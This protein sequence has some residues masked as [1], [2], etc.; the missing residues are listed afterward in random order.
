[1]A[2]DQSPIETSVELDAFT[3]PTV[4]NVQIVG[5]I[6]GTKAGAKYG[7][8]Y[9]TRQQVLDSGDRVA[10]FVYAD[11]GTKDQR[12]TEINYVSATFPGITIKREFTYTLVSGRYRRDSETWEEV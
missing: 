6:D 9:N 5:S 4:D 8:V 7:I 2:S 12:I 10:N 11:F 3:K 1:M